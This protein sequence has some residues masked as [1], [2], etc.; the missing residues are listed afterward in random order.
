MRTSI[1]LTLAAGALIS[2]TA[3]LAAPPPPQA[4]GAAM[5]K[6]LSGSWKAPEYKVRLGGTL[7]LEVW[8]EGASK[9]RNVTLTLKSS[10]EGLV[11][12]ENSI[13]DPQGKTRQ[14]S[15]SVTEA[16]ITVGPP[17]A[18]DPDRPVVTVTKADERYLDDRGNRRTI[19]GVRISLLPV[20]S[21]PNL[22]NFRFDTPAGHGSFGETLRRRK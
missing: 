9:L 20:A 14:Y 21:N 5:V 15:A 4:A 18:D 2:G 7:D 3:M 19:E 11:T 6:Q 12:I 13:V 1:T 8:G 10:G 17:R 16:H 22:L